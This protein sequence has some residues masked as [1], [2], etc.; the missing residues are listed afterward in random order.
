[1]ARSG[2]ITGMPMQSSFKPPK[3]KYCILGKQT[4]SPV[5]K[6]CTEGEGHRATHKLEKV[7][8]DLSGPHAVQSRAGNSYVMNI[9]D[10]YT[11]HPW[12]IPLKLKSDA[13]RELQ[14]WEL[15]RENETGLQVGT[16]ITNNG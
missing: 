12:S 15:A 16:Y 1:M 5:P 14:S 7:W 2:Y 13:F 9:V 11:W 8:V 10:N 6:K 3:C 4:Q